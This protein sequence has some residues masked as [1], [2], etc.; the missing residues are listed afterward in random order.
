[1]AHFPNMHNFFLCLF[2]AAPVAYG[3]SQAKDQFGVVAA[4]LYHSSQQHWI[5]NPL[6]EARDQTCVLMGPSQI[7]FHWAMIAT[8]EKNFFQVL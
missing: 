1:M 7:H 4:G 3:G 6:S 2:R 8:P 5:L